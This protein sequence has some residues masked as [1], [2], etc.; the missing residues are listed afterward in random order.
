MFYAQLNASSD[1]TSVWGTDVYTDDSSIC[2]AAIHAGLI[3][4]EG[5][6]VTVWKTPG[7]VSYS[8]STRNG[9]TT[10]HY[11]TW[12]RHLNFLISQIQLLQNPTNM[13]TQNIPVIYIT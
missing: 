2:R 12:P 7:H 5:G 13:I 8:G 11:G 9:I 4:N 6:E 10:K 3:P 1:G